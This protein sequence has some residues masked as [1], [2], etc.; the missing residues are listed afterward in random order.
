MIDDEARHLSQARRDVQDLV[1]KRNDLKER[2]DAAGR[3]APAVRTAVTAETADV[4]A[5]LS[6]AERA[7]TRLTAL[8]KDRPT[9]MRRLVD[10]QAV[11]QGALY[12]RLSEELSRAGVAPVA[13]VGEDGVAVAAPPAAATAA[14]FAYAAL[15]V[16]SGCAMHVP[17]GEVVTCTEC[18][19]ELCG[20]GGRS[21]D[22]PLAWPCVSVAK[23]KCGIS[24]ACYDCISG[25][26]S[27]TALHWRTCQASG[28]GTWMCAKECDAAVVGCATCGVSPMCKGCRNGHRCHDDDDE[29]SGDGTSS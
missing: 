1:D 25:V 27:R 13:P 23:C 5:K 2:Y 22:A 9:R 29:S 7:V 17:R 16:C 15:V 18:S 20:R 14:A 8:A 24:T 21:P 28:C 12:H 4:I 11:A 26:T 19:R 3:A 10:Q 6:V